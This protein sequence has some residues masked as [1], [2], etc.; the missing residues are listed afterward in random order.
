M[1][2]SVLRPSTRPIAAPWIVAALAVLC[3]LT[4]P[5]TAG[6][7]NCIDPAAIGVSRTVEIDA[8]TGG[9]YGSMTAR[10]RRPSFLR[11][12]EVVLTF[13]DGPMPWVTRSILDTLEKHCARATFFATGRMAMAYPATVRDI[14]ARG[15]TLG[16]H[17]YSHPFRLPRMDKARATDEIE[18]GFAAVASAAGTPVAPFFRFTG[19][20]DSD[21]LV[22]YLASRGAA[23]F[24]VDIVS[25]DSYIHDAGTLTARTLAEVDAR[26]GG[27]LL[28]HDIKTTTA[29]ALPAILDGLK[30]RGYRVAHLAARAPME[31]RQDLMSEYA[32]RVAKLVARGSK[33][34]RIVPFYGA[35]GPSK[36]NILGE[37]EVQPAPKPRLAK[38]PAR[39]PASNSAQ[40]PPASQSAAAGSIQPHLSE[41]AG[42]VRAASGSSTTA[43]SAW[44][45]GSIRSGP[46]VVA[47]EETVTAPWSL[48]IKNSAPASQGPIGKARTAR[49][50]A[51]P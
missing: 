37:L 14:V 18:R 26:G 31:P 34:A 35:L 32:P 3:S 5:A 4:P 24:S 49:P 47:H 30:A 23:A 42:G 15:H 28:F 29:K 13:D 41:K 21:A 10:T 11:S 20:S 25:N 6:P 19:L 36:E 50:N 2:R 1:D 38:K 8:S 39:A 7:A 40:E 12:K 51:G 17:T 33:D 48:E 22:D 44:E 43:S 27:I 46:P 45:T 16:S 9:I